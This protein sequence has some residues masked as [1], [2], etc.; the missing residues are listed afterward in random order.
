MAGGLEVTESRVTRPV[1]GAMTEDE[2]A[3]DSHVDVSADAAELVDADVDWPQLPQIE[4]DVC[5]NPEP[6]QLGRRAPTDH[7]QSQ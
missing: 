6:M 5:L 1:R 7:E 2:L 4:L 3:A